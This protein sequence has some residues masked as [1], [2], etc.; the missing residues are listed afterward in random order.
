MLVLLYKLALRHA[1]MEPG[2]TARQLVSG[3][4]PSTVFEARRLLKIQYEARF[5]PR[6][7]QIRWPSNQALLLA[8]P[9]LD[10]D[11]FQSLS[12]HEATPKY[13]KLMLRELCSRL[14]AAVE[15]NCSD[16][17]SKGVAE[18][19]FPEADALLLERYA[20]LLATSS[21]GLGITSNDVVPE[22][23]F[24]T[25]YW[26]TPKQTSRNPST[27][28]VLDGFEGITIREEGSAVSKGTTGLRTWEAGLRLASHIVGHPYLVT[29][30]KTRIVEL[31]SGTGFL[32]SVCA[33]ISAA[34]HT[35]IW[36]T[37][38]PGQVVARICDT[39]ALNKLDDSPDVRVQGLDWLEL[40]EERQQSD[41]RDDLPTINF[42]KD[43]KPTLVLAADVV[44]D[45]DLVEALA[46][47]IRACLNSGH[48][49]GSQALIASTIRNASTYEAFKTALR[50]STWSPHL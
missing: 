18:I 45:P 50:K 3:P 14:E 34:S 43:A 15:E 47:T 25:H 33:K 10:H 22:E 16:L 36:L 44:Y 23:E 13:Q 12:T 42:L 32:G 41:Q 39:L 24:T 30:P 19:E 29:S 4:G 26:P 2:D 48:R 11:L 38:V 5:P 49:D 28:D 40:Q 1:R 8:Q 20:A 37:D 21:C 17:R 31:G 27:N 7:A 9:H 6:S 35:R 46:G